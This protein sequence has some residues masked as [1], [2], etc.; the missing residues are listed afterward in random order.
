MFCQSITQSTNCHKSP[1]FDITL[2]HCC[3]LLDASLRCSWPSHTW[4]SEPRSRARTE[5]RGSASGRKTPSTS[6]PR[7]T[8]T[9]GREA[10]SAAE[11]QTH[12]RTAQRLH[13]QHLTRFGEPCLKRK[14]FCFS[15]YRYKH[16]KPS[17]T[18]YCAK[19]QHNRSVSLLLVVNATEGKSERIYSRTARSSLEG[20]RVKGSF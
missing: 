18:I 12:N 15:N 6:T 5:Q 2:K 7:E 1:T 19:L 8:E 11:T 3:L 20:T 4:C 10:K 14:V 13:T 9:A 16:L 17:L